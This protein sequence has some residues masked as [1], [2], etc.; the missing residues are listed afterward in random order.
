MWSGD[1]G[2]LARQVSLNMALGAALLLFSIRLI[3]RNIR[4]N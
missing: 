1:E 3:C 2:Y 4:Q